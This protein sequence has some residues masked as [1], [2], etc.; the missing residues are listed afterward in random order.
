MS[1]PVDSFEKV[2]VNDEGEYICSAF[3]VAGNSSAS[4]VLKVRSP[5][6]ITITPSNFVEVVLGDPVLV[7]C[8]A[9]GYPEPMVSIQSESQ[10]LTT[11]F[12]KAS[13]VSS[14]PLYWYRLRW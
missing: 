3:N 11:N 7:E 8:R 1:S 9:H 5:P 13:S 10:L 12:D 2:D 14:V 4:A 6:V